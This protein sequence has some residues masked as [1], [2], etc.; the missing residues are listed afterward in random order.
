MAQWDDIR[1]IADEIELKIHLASMEARARWR[2]LQPRLV[3]L[4]RAL[5]HSVD[6]TGDVIAKELTSVDAAVRRLREEITTKS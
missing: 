6:R 3:D 4:E 1:R 2:G 5:T